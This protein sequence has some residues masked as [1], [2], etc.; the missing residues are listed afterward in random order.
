[1]GLRDIL[2]M[3][4]GGRKAS[5]RWNEPACYRLRL[6]GDLWL[7]LALALAGWAA[8]TGVLLVLFAINVNP[9]G[10]ALAAG[11]GLVFGLGPA[12]LLLFLGESHVSGR[13]RIDDDGIHRHRTYA[14]LTL[15]G[16]WSESSDWPWAAIERCVIV[17]GEE[18]GRSFSILLLSV[19]GD[20]EPV[21]VPRRISLKSLAKHCSARGVSV[22]HGAKLPARLHR[23][24]HPGI[25]G[26]FVAFGLVLMT[27]GSVF[28]GQRTGDDDVAMDRPRIERP[29]EFAFRDDA[30]GDDQADW[31]AG[32]RQGSGSPQ[33]VP[34]GGAGRPESPD[35]ASADTTD[36]SVPEYGGPRRHSSPPPPASVP[37][38]RPPGGSPQPGAVVPEYRPG[39]APEASP[40]G[41]PAP[42]GLVGGAG[43]AP[44]QTLGPRGA[45]VVGVRY[46]QGSWAGQ[47][48]LRSLEPVFI[49]EV[50]PAAGA[51]EA[52]QGEQ[53]LVARDG[54]AVGGLHVDAGPYVHAVQV[55]YMR[56]AADGR[57]DATDSYTSSWLGSRTGGPV[58]T[59]GGTGALVIGI[60][61]RRAAVLDAVGLVSK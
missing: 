26:G 50:D 24:L 36:S 34:P 59:L 12:V 45:P 53:V 27:A 6:R 5:F 28:Y 23:G 51:Q 17:P 44:F 7:R 46:S 25:A 29:D 48:A 39:T 57:L 61:G 4:I 21:A 1:M 38:Y 18:I 37:E 35:P 11:L 56:L 55:I 31:S 54:Y 43:G 8:A 60:K 3:E 20:S 47:P 41:G 30:S 52:A 10:I 33:S 13:V 16:I 32:V 40:R 42:D 19:G 49:R 2:T 22:A 58:Q 15:T 9:P 14:A